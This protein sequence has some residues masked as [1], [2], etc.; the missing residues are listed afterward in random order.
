M[1]KLKGLAV[2]FVSA[3]FIAGSG[4]ASASGAKN[5]CAKNPCVTNPC[6]KNPCGAKKKS[7]RSDRITDYKKLVSMGEKMWN[8]QKLGGSGMSCMTCHSDHESLNLDRHHGRWP[9]NVPKMTDDIFTL[10]QMINFCML[11]P[12]EGKALDAHGMEMTAMEAYYYQY[13]ASY[14]GAN[15][16]ANKKSNPCGR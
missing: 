4:S 2:L 1:Y 14:K 16:C 7:I 8:N 15:P 9:H 11:N 3:F 12:M 5:P 13:I 10:T 6:A